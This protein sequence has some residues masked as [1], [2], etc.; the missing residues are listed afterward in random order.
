MT[1]LFERIARLNQNGVFAVDGGN[2]DDAEQQHIEALEIATLAVA[3][4]ADHQAVSVANLA[5]IYRRRDA[6]RWKAEDRLRSVQNVFPSK[7][8]FGQARWNEE[9]ALVLKYLAGKEPK[10]K[11]DDLTKALILARRA[12]EF[13]ANARDNDTPEIVDRDTIENRLLRT[14]GIAS[15]IAAELARITEGDTRTSYQNDAITY[16]QQ[17]VDG[18][19]KRRETSGDA[20][21][22]AYHTLGVA[23]TEM[24]K[25]DERGYI[26][27]KLNFGRAQRLALEEGNLLVDSV[28][29]FRLAWLEYVANPEN[30]T[31]IEG[32]G[33]K[34]LDGQEPDEP[35][36]W[37]AGV[38]ATL[39]EQMLTLGRHVGPPLQERV[40]AF[41]SPETAQ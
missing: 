2:Y 37:D 21:A 24:A 36:R 11:L 39:K 13:Y 15:T 25:G 33:S 23:Q 12:V 28:I 18:R 7:T 34:V 10:Q 35:G 41:Y 19:V 26:D 14:T 20:L 30:R 27:A 22:N 8:L 17:E 29:N 5:F 31:G 38:K 4:A 3:H 1:N 9:Y 6:D 40:E 16:A 32:Y